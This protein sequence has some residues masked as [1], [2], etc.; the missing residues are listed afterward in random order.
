MITA[1]GRRRL[2]CRKLSTPTTSSCYSI[3]SFVFHAA[4]QHR[5]NSSSIK[6][7]TPEG[8]WDSHMHVI[9]PSRY[10]FPQNATVP[11]EASIADAF[12]NARRLGLPNMVFVQISGYGTNNT[13][14]LEALKTHGGRGVVSFDPD[15]IDV[16]TLQHWHDLGVRGVRLNLRSSKKEM[17]ATEIQTVLR[18]YAD[19]LRPL[20]TWSIGLYADMAMLEHV[21]PIVRELGVKIV[22]E[23]FGSPAHLPLNTDNTPGW[24]AMCKMMED[25]NVFVKISGP[26][27]FSHQNGKKDGFE[28]FEGLTKALLRMR[29]GEGVVFASDWPHTQ[30]RGFDVM[31][32]TEKC[33]EWCEG[34]RNLE[35]KLFRDDAKVLWDVN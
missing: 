32:F 2:V 12:T 17:S 24:K 34:D 31:P 20:K 9:E 21:Q 1:L 4:S 27:L 15:N 14:I 3:T 28:D 35:N 6:L 23:H 8:S 33:L 25:P 10:P 29:N 5:Y 7:I 16:S 19:K 26:Y 11:K 30:S 13:W 18:K 22:L